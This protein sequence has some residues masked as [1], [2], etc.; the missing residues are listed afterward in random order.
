LNNIIPQSLQ[1]SP[2]KPLS[3]RIR[4]QPKGDQATD[5]IGDGSDSQPMSESN[6]SSLT[7]EKEILINEKGEI[8]GEKLRECFSR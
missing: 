2:A 6:F 8:V 5:D 3:S 7:E 4:S 1:K